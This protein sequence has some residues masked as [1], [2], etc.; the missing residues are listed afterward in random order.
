MVHKLLKLENDRRRVLQDIA[1]LRALF[2]RHP[3]LDWPYIQ[4]RVAP[5]SLPL[6]RAIR[7]ASDEELLERL[8][9]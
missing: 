7:E 2:Q 5:A 9:D 6:L 3:S 8:K 1:D 4:R